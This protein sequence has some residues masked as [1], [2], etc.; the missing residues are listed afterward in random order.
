MLEVLTPRKAL[1]VRALTLG[2]SRG[3]VTG[4]PVCLAAPCHALT[5]PVEK[6]AKGAIGWVLAPYHASRDCRVRWERDRRIKCPG[7]RT[8][9][10]RWAASLRSRPVNSHEPVSVF[11]GC[12]LVEPLLIRTTLFPC[13]RPRTLSCFD[14][15]VCDRGGVEFRSL[16]LC[17]GA[18]IICVG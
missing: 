11:D 13:S 18:L 5:H 10:T 4:R 16:D 14:N 15:H 6:A 3:V 12:C 7:S 17:T 8:R 1:L 9:V 2:V